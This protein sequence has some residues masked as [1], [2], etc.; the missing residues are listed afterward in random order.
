MAAGARAAAGTGGVER[1]RH[2]EVCPIQYACVC[3][4]GDACNAQDCPKPKKESFYEMALGFL[5]ESIE[6]AHL[7]E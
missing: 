7:S 6:G 3:K 4:E 1:T 2:L 5:M